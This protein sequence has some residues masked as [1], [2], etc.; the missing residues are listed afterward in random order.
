MSRSQ[1]PPPHQP[2]PQSWQSN[3]GQ[4]TLYPGFAPDP[5]AEY[6]APWFGYRK[7][8]K[9]GAWATRSRLASNVYRNF[10]LPD[11]R[12]VIAGFRTC[13]L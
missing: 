2:P 11:R 3:Y 5:Y 4:V 12:D 10:F 7:V 13:A 9:G 1:A 8:L 6:S